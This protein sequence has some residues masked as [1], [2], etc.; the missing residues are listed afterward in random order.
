VHALLPSI[1]EFAYT[2]NEHPEKQHDIELEEQD[3][4]P[5]A[6]IWYDFPNMSEEAIAFV[7]ILF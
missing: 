4:P 3:I 5:L 2:S 7:G 6:K 1:L